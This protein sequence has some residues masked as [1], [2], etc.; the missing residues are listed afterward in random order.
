MQQQFQAEQAKRKAERAKFLTDLA[1]LLGVDEAKLTAALKANPI[2]FGG[3]LGFGGPDGGPHGFGPPGGPGMNGHGFFRHR[4]L[5]ARRQG[6]RK[7]NNGANFV[8]PNSASGASF[9]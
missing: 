4:G 9:S 7:S 3:G 2:G 8:L 6:S 1:G 5:H